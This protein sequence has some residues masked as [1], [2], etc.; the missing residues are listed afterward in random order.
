[1]RQVCVKFSVLILLSLLCTRASGQFVYYGENPAGLRWMQ[2]ETQD[3][4]VI[5]PVGM[6]SLAKRYLWLLEQNRTAVMAGLGGINPKQIP[7][8]LNNRTARSNGTVVWAPKRMELY[9]IPPTDNYPQAWD[10]QLA[11]HESRHVGQMTWFTKGFYKWLGVLIG[12]Q[13]PSLGVAIYPSRW[14]LEGDAVVAETELSNAGRGRNAEFLEYYRAAAMEGENRKWN[15]WRLGSY[16]RYTPN[17]YAFGYLLNSTIRYTTGNYHY[18]GEVF[19]GLVKNFY[20]PNVT[21]KNYRQSVGNKPQ[22]FFALGYDM[23]GQMWKE[24]SSKRGNFTVAE[25]L[26]SK[27]GKDYR[28][29]YSPVGIGT[30]SLLYVRYSYNNPSQLVLVHDGKEKVLKA[31]SAGTKGLQRHGDLIYYAAHNPSARW[32]KEV[33]SDIYTYNVKSGTTSQITAG[34]YYFSPMIS[35]GGD[36]LLVEE[37]LPQGGSRLAILDSRTG[38]AERKISAPYNGQITESVWLGESIYA[39]VVTEYGLGLYRTGNS[40]G[41]EN[42]IEDQNASI[43]D[44]QATEDALYFLSDMDGVRNVYMFYPMEGKLQ[45]LTNSEYGASEPYI[46]E[47]AL[48]YSAMHLKGKYPVR[49][50]LDTIAQS[51]SEYEPLFVVEDQSSSIKGRIHAPYRYVVAEALTQQAKGALGEQ[52]YGEKLVPEEEFAN[53]VQARKYSKAGHLLRFHSWAPVY[54]NVDRIMDFDFDQIHRAVALGATAYSQNT[55]G[56]ATTMLGYSYHK[57]FHAGHLKFKYSGWYPVLQISA[58]VNADQRYMVKLEK[59]DS[60]INRVMQPVGSPLVE[61]E[62]ITYIPFNFSSNGWQRGVVPQVGWDFNN[63]GHY[64]SAKGGY[65]YSNTLTGALQAYTMREMAPSGI[66]PKWGLG[67][68]AKWRTAINGGE[69]FGSAASLYLYGYAPGVAPTHGIKLSLSLQKQNVEGK[70]YY[71]GNMVSMPRGFEDQMYGEKYCMATA[72]YAFPVYMGDMSLLGLAY[73]KRMQIIPY[74]D[75][76]A[77]SK[78]VGK[79]KLQHTAL[80]SY[81]G[82]ILFDLC[83]FMLGVDISIGVRYSRYGQDVA[84][85]ATKWKNGFGLMVSTSLF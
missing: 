28:E 58:D 80:Y 34:G 70:N 64:D 68:V 7:V 38:K 79:G 45:R 74:A 13:S 41:W 76:A 2:V 14:M 35:R 16:K 53:R 31:I 72:D 75:I 43:T 21:G 11:I 26:L 46:Y 39:L 27:K 5:Y 23:M 40:G 54:Y 71:G 81:G 73:L 3:Y 36:S 15:Q 44:L 56:T 33:F 48:Y 51:G 22:H 63:N 32:S 12:Q 42:I 4:K 19:D 61:L 25:Q 18:A 49:I 1:M 83:P 37:Y 29:Y 6:D 24:E 85:A 20:N 84:G 9:T 65:I 59:G 30:D 62:A 77:L 10:R 17:H 60:T 67:T 47:G 82:A 78:S 55:L 66:Y 8:L 50:Q 52:Y 57:G 69:N